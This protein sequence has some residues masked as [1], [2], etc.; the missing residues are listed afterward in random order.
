MDAG[1]EHFVIVVPP[2]AV[3]EGRPEPIMVILKGGPAR[4]KGRCVSCYRERF[5]IST[6]S[7]VE[8]PRDTASFPSFDQANLW[9]VI[10]VKRVS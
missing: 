8:V 9:M 7:L 1:G 3:E 10:S 2:A 6:M 5:L 4:N